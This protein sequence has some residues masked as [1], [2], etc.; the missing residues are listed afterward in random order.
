MSKV[1]KNSMPYWENGGR[2]LGVHMI[3]DE[4]SI[5]SKNRYINVKL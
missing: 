1:K 5:E 4:T 3:V 2:D